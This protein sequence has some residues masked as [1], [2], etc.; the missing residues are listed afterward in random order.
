M[1]SAALTLLRHLTNVLALVGALGVIAMLLHVTADVI[2]RLLFQRPVPATVEIVSRYY[3][4]LISFLPLAW[5][6]R[7]NEM[8]TVDILSGLFR[9]PLDRINMA[10]VHLLSLAAFIFLAYTTWSAALREYEAGSFVLSLSVAVP[11]WPGYFLLPLAFALAS[12][13]SAVKLYLCLAGREREPESE[14][15]FETDN[16]GP[17]Q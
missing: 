2:S 12:L 17:V 4:V 13:I 14:A 9:G 3:M 16:G 8:I 6:E 5:T 15:F 7:R 10:F 11:I 1:R